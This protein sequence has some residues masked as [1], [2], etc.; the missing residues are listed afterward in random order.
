[1][2]VLID[3]RGLGLRGC[4]GEVYTATA[5]AECPTSEKFNT[6]SLTPTGPGTEKC[7]PGLFLL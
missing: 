5:D 3:Y 4:E 7:C 1:M 6:G 2:C